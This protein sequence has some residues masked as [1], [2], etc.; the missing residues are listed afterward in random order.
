MEALASASVGIVHGDAVLH[1]TRG[2]TALGQ[3]GYREA[4]VLTPLADQGARP[5]ESVFGVGPKWQLVPERL[6]R[7]ADCREYLAATYP[8]TSEDIGV[9]ALPSIGALGLFEREPNIP[10]GVGADHHLC[11]LLIATAQ[12]MRERRRDFVLA[13]FTVS[14]SWLVIYR[15]GELIHAQSRPMTT[16]PDAVFFAAALL[17]QFGLDRDATPV[18]VGGAISSEGQLLRELVVYFDVRPLS[19]AVPA[20]AAPAAMHL[21][22]AYGRVLRDGIYALSTDDNA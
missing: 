8:S 2:D 21:L 7:H 5:H 17:Q 18:Y 6:Y 4:A 1:F 16:G 11:E 10:A 14:H 13:F 22:L 3:Y 20:P 9:V 15:R 12:A 19:K